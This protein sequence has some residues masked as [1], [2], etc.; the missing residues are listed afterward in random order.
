MGPERIPRKFLTA[1][2][3]HPRPHGRPQ[4]TFGHSLNK[5]LE[6]AGITTDFKTWSQMAQDRASWRARIY[7]LA[8]YPTPP[9][10]PPVGGTPH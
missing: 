3:R 10:T 7:G 1:W 5:T 6:R 2:V 8:E 4:Y 9:W